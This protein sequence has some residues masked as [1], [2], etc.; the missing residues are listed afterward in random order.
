MFALTEL[1]IHP[2][3]KVLVYF[4]M[5]YTRDTRVPDEMPLIPIKRTD[6]DIVDQFIS[7]LLGETTLSNTELVVMYLVFVWF[8]HYNVPYVDGDVRK[9]A[10]EGSGVEAAVG[11]IHYR[12]GYGGTLRGLLRETRRERTHVRLL[13]LT[14]APILGYK[15]L[16]H[17]GLGQRLGGFLI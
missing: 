17:G 6:V 14:Q 4:M 12:R 1:E 11:L 3:D 15:G 10:V 5:K 9:L 7:V 13:A 2:A 16:G 8:G